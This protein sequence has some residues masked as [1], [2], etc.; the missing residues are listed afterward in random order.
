MLAFKLMEKFEAIEA[1]IKEACVLDGRGRTGGCLSIIGVTNGLLGTFPIGEVV[2]VGNQLKYWTFC[3]EK[4][5][6]LHARCHDISSWQTREPESKKYGGAV[7]A[8]DGSS[9]GFSGLSEHWDEAVSAATAKII[10]PSS[11]PESRIAEIAEISKNPHIV[12]FCRRF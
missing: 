7:T 9:Y 11:M 3:Q 4:V 5:C 2:D 12:E 10:D 6:R 8:T 1:M